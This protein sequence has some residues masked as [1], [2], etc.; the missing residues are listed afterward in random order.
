[1]YKQFVTT[2]CIL[3]YFLHDVIKNWITIK[4]W[5]SHIDSVSHW[6]CLHSGPRFNIKI[7]SYQYRKSHCGDKTVVRSSYLHNGISYTGKMTSFYWIRALLIVSQLITWCIMQKVK[8]GIW[9][10]AVIL[11]IEPLGTKLSEIWIEIHIFSFKKMHLK[12]LSGKWQPF[13]LSSMC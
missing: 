1:M 13:C 11:L 9:T 10:N 7:L 12:M 3:F 8:S 5:S 6:H 4:R 2:V